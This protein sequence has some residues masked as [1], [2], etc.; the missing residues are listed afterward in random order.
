MEGRCCALENG[1]RAVVAQ[2]CPSARAG[3]E[4]AEAETDEV[5]GIARAAVREAR[6]MDAWC[7][8]H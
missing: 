2:G 8:P 5:R 3:R 4:A 6:E 1:E 7:W